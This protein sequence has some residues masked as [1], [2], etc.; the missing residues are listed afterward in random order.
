MI[1]AFAAVAA[2]AQ[3]SAKAKW[4]IMEANSTEEVRPELV[5]QD[6]LAVSKATAAK[7]GQRAE[8]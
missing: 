2:E 5:R 6:R 3:S 8:G 7:T 1:A 4:F